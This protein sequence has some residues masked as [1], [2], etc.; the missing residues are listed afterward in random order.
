MI[1]AEV[2]AVLGEDRFGLG[3][4]VAW[5]TELHILFSPLSS[6]FTLFLLSSI[7][8][9]GFHMC[10]KQRH[11]DLGDLLSGMGVFCLIILSIAFACP[12]LLQRLIN[13]LYDSEVSSQLFLTSSILCQ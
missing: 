9:P 13:V 3:D 12:S 2:E 5:L 8:E 6:C 11:D 7:R 4:F 10:F 1:L